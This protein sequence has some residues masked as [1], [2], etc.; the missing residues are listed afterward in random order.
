MEVS[1]LEDLSTLR[2]CT[3]LSAVSVNLAKLLGGNLVIYV[4]RYALWALKPG[5]RLTINAPNTIDS[6]S[7]VPRKWS[8]Q[9]LV[10]IIAKSCSD[11]GTIIY[12]DKASRKIICFRTKDRQGNAAWSAGVIYSGMP[13]ETKQLKRCINQLL[14]QPE[15]IG[16]GQIVVC[17]PPSGRSHIEGFKDV[18]Y[19]QMET[20][21]VSG[22]FMIGKKKMDLIRYMKNN[23]VLIC[24]TRI[25]LRE[26]CIKS[27]PDEFDVITPCVWIK[28]YKTK[29]P[30]LDLGFFE[31]SSA[32]MYSK[33]AQPSIAYN[34]SNWMEYL[35]RYYPYIDG[36][37]FCIRRELALE[38]PINS[39]IAW[40]EAED[41]EWCMRLT[42]LGKAVELSID[43]QAE[44]A[45]SKMPR[46]SRYG[47]SLL[48]RLI[49]KL[50]R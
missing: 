14:L 42:H 44:S 50:I 23:K 22:R 13:S 8:F 31:S 33:R 28:G 25:E 24:H 48:Y 29:L 4:I 37:L 26:S 15:I 27:L 18:E 46:Y 49:Q 17:G 12:C 32:S 16:S 30:Y 36:G 40:A 9:L 11:L 6:A 7:L 21:T 38:V 34:R 2:K 5:G 43:A 47:H 39:E 19:L 1:K 35:C 45:T 10:Q 3:D 20:P 41:S